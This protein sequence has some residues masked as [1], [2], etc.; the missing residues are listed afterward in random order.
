MTPPQEAQ[1]LDPQNTALRDQAALLIQKDTQTK[2]VT[3]L[4]AGSRLGVGR[5]GVA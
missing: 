5:I 2:S 1:A 4:E 3:T